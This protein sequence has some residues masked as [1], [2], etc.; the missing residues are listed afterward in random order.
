MTLTI[1]PGVIVKYSGA[2]EILIKGSIIANGTADKIISFI[3]SNPGVSSDA[4]I[5]VFKGTDLSTS[6][7]SYLKMEDADY[8]IKIGNNPANT[9]TLTISHVEITNAQVKTEGNNTTAKLVLS[10][11][12]ISTRIT[13][14]NRS[15]PI[16]IKNA[17]IS[18]SSLLSSGGYRYSYNPYHRDQGGII[19]M[20]KTT[21]SNSNIRYSGYFYYGHEIKIE[22]LSLSDSSIYFNTNNYDGYRMIVD[23]TS[24]NN[25]NIEF[26]GQVKITDS[27]LQNS[28][29]SH[30]SNDLYT[31][32]EVLNSQLINTRIHLPQQYVNITN[33]TINYDIDLAIK[34]GGGTISNSDI[35]G[36][37]SNI[38]LEITDTLDSY[39][40]VTTP[41][42]ISDSIIMN[43]SI[44]IKI[45]GTKQKDITI[46]NNSLVNNATYS[47]ENLSWQDITT[48]NNYWGTTDKSQIEEKIYH[49]RDNINYGM[50]NY[51]SY[52]NA[53]PR[54][55]PTIE[56]YK[57]TVNKDGTGT[58]SVTG[59]GV[60][61]GDDC[62]ELYVKDKPLVLTA[63]STESSI[64]MG[65]SGGGC[66]GTENCTITM[67][68]NQN[69]TATFNINNNIGNNKFRLT[70]N[71]TGTG[72]GNVT[73]QGISCGN[74]C[75]KEYLENT[76]ITLSA[77]ATAG[78]SF[79]GWT[80]A[81][82]GTENCNITITQHQNVTAIFN[83]N[84]SPEPPTPPTLVT[85]YTPI[86]NN[87]Q[88]AAEITF[89]QFMIEIYEP[90]TNKATGEYAIYSA[91]AESNFILEV[92][93]G[94]N[95]VRIPSAT[96]NA[97]SNMIPVQIVPIIPNRAASTYDFKYPICSAA[98]IGANNNSLP[99]FSKQQQS[100]CI[101][102]L[103]VP[104]MLNLPDGSDIQ[105]RHECLEIQ[106]DI[107]PTQNATFK[108]KQIRK[109]PTS[110]CQ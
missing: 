14:S 11:A 5:L 13:T 6:Q 59:Q 26:K 67:N 100:F 1:E 3:S 101:P 44:G 25:T 108:I 51:T 9:G 24:I 73:G 15:E 99:A 104:N 46:E 21:V 70:V 34:L 12:S 68:Q 110:L 28:N 75:S 16:E 48:T 50:V 62:T 106:M 95:N 92:L 86:I 93:P 36:N 38:G 105:L 98:Q 4:R 109:I 42:I 19:T 81:C 77:N 66:S 47:L 88:K 94:F 83:D 91:P 74:D 52:K 49:Y 29:I 72:T 53:P 85:N 37:G 45:T 2:Y 64:F 103:K 17:T 80:G 90:L 20:E 30:T 60:N 55:L 57:L 43:N 69:V 58:G 35:I 78:S 33:S 18:N 96:I 76:E 107:T 61:C 7:L 8:S 97:F 79:I 102:N 22:N 32:L 23:N 27:S 41:V 40:N 31:T 56:R 65:W 10:D 54:A 71:K 63:T 39:G 87:P 82:S 84:N 89:K